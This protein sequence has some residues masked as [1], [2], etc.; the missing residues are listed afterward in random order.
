MSA[1]PSRRTF[2]SSP[3]GAN[4]A[5]FAVLFARNVER[6]GIRDE[7]RGDWELLSP[8]VGAGAPIWPPAP[9]A[10]RFDSQP[11]GIRPPRS[12]PRHS[13]SL[14]GPG[15]IRAGGPRMCRPTPS[16][17]TRST[18]IAR[19]HVARQPK[20]KSRRKSIACRTDNGRVAGHRTR[21][22]WAFVRV[23]PAHSYAKP[24]NAKHRRT[25]SG[26]VRQQRC[27]TR[28][29]HRLRHANRLRRPC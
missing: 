6:N 11:S 15:G 28:P 26:S 12:R 18:G 21:P 1:V 29:S 17:E 27:I 9:A 16:G 13:R 10:D 5:Q 2:A 7:N 20:R 3:S 23:C 4:Q 8:G 14:S 24:D 19:F 22:L 25:M